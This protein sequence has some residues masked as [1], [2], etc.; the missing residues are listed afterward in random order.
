MRAENRQRGKWIAGGAITPV[1]LAEK[2]FGWNR[3][4]GCHGEKGEPIAVS[5]DVAFVAEPG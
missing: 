1:Q 3:S 2:L 5:R 4:A